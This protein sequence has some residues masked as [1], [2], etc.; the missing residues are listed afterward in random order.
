MQSLKL[1]LHVI[2][3]H[4]QLCFIIFTISHHPFKFTTIFVTM[5]QPQNCT[6]IHIDQIIGFFIQ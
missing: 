2:I 6:S 4:L 3:Y 1:Q 5:V